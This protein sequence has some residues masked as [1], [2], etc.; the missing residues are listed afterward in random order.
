MP[1][2]TS[3]EAM[4]AALL[5]DPDDLVRHAAYADML[6]E[7]GDPRGDF[8]R[9][10]LQ[11]EERKLA[12]KVRKKLEKQ[13]AELLKQHER[14]WLGPLYDWRRSI[15]AHPRRMIFNISWCRGWFDRIVLNAP[16]MKCIRKLADAPLAKLVTSLDV[17]KCPRDSTQLLAKSNWPNLR[18]LTFFSLT[19]MNPVVALTSNASLCRLMKLS[20]TWKDN[21]RNQELVNW[22]NALGNSSCLPSLIELSLGDMNLSD[23]SIDV[24]LAS[25][26]VKKLSVLHLSSSMITDDGALALAA[27]P[28]TSKLK[29]LN[30]TYNYITEIGIDAFQTLG[31]EVWFDHQ[32]D[33]NRHDDEG[34]L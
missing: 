1:L 31:M 27:H 8:I 26:I 3:R 2:M 7:D 32:F 6:I 21:G 23:D 11:L 20:V 12:A 18:N 30:L 16:D 10:Q 13:S 14:E 24:L 25:G 15:S 22:L 9:I 34:D 28:D 19:S 17:H 33:G 4:E 5:D 29:T